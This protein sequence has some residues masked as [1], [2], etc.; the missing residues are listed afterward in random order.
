MLRL[1]PARARPMT[2]FRTFTDDDVRRVLPMD[3]AIEA[4]REAFALLDAGRVEMPLRASVPLEAPG[5]R[6]LVMAARAGGWYGAKLVTVLPDGPARDRPRVQAV[7]LLFDPAT[8]APVAR[9]DAEA[10]TAIRTGAASGL[11]TGHLARQDATRV[12]IL[13]AGAQARTQLEAVCRVRAIAE[14]AVWSRS[15]ERAAA[16]GT[17]MRE[18]PG[19]PPV[20]TCTSVADAVKEADIVCAATAS[21]VP[22][23][24]AR[25]L[26]PGMH[27]NAVGSFRPDMR[28]LEAGV[29]AGARVV[30][31]Q[32]EA[33][34]AEAGEVIAAVRE[35]ALRAD[36][37]VELGAVVT[38]RARGRERPEQ[39]T[40]FKSVGLAVQDVVA[41]AAVY[42]RSS[43]PAARGVF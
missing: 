8:D 31:D 1:D 24:G 7:L 32:R 42:R 36:A 27:V 9:F 5:G 11:A 12:A 13:G 22:V 33:A 15:P 37:L 10:L 20:R 16:F 38:G 29:L 40:V 14:A 35:N 21:P 28:E 19:M 41:A 30:V 6:F 25:H 3:D 17:A 26:R 4:M 43:D 23:L 18:V 39:I 2:P 34:L